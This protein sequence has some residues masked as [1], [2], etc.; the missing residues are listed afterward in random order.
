MGGEAKRVEGVKERGDLGSDGGRKGLE[1]GGEIGGSRGRREREREAKEG[2]EIPE[3][4]LEGVRGGFGLGV[5][6]GES[7]DRMGVGGG[8]FVGGGVI[9]SGAGGAPPEEEEEGQEEVKEEGLEAEGGEVIDD[10]AFD[11]VAVVVL[12]EKKKTLFAVAMEDLGDQ[13]EILALRK[14]VVGEKPVGREEE[15]A[16]FAVGKENDHWAR[17]EGGE[18]RGGG[19]EFGEGAKGEG[20]GL[21]KAVFDLSE[22]GWLFGVAWRCAG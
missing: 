2:V 12:V 11:R 3:E 22:G 15:D 19:R 7:G 6:S 16:A 8:I 20:D 1:V 4:E 21:L 10:A 5:E 17:G 9:R 13:S 18:D 14:A